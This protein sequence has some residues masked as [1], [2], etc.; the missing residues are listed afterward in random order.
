MVFFWVYRE[1]G[2]FQVGGLGFWGREQVGGGDR[3]VVHCVVSRFPRIYRL[4][5]FESGKQGNI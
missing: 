5:K 3:W 1:R 2:F 4:K